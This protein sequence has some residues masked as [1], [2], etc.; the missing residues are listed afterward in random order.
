M[1]PTSWPL[2]ALFWGKPRASGDDPYGPFLSVRR[3]E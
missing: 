2:L 3:Q 1:I